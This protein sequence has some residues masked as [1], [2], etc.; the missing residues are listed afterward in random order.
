MRSRS[1]RDG[2]MMARWGLW[3]TKQKAT[4]V[5]NK[6]TNGQPSSTRESK[7]RTCDGEYVHANPGKRCLSDSGFQEGIGQPLVVPNGLRKRA[8]P[9]D[10]QAEHCKEGTS[11]AEY[12]FTFSVFV[13]FSR[14]CCAE[15][16]RSA[17]GVLGSVMLVKGSLDFNVN[18]FSVSV[19]FWH[20]PKERIDR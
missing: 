20:T 18:V 5:V 12:K 13:R 1:R 17:V 14:C 7:R 3:N 19:H 2:A 9:G 4:R 11:K 10:R 15:L 6:E 8:L 16:A